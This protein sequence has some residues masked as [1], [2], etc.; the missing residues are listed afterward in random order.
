MQLYTDAD[1]IPINTQI[2][3]HIILNKWRICN[4]STPP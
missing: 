1:W 3:M 2:Y 4:L